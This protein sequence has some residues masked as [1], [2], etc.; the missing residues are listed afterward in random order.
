MK[1]KWLASVMSI[2][3]AVSVLPI[4]GWA[5]ESAA[6]L[7]SV[8]ETPSPVSLSGYLETY[9]VRDFNDP[10]NHK[11]PDFLYSHNRANVLSVNLAMLKASLNTQRLRG[12]LALGSGSYMR[13][14]YAAEPKG[15][16]NIFEANVGVKLSGSHDL[17]LDAGVM[18]SHLGFE[19]AVGTE[20]WTLTRGLMAEN[21]PYF[22]TGAKL[23]YT[24]ADG[25]WMASGLL[26][27][28]WQ[29]IRAPQGN[30][31]PSIG[32]QLTYKP[33]DRVTLNS[34]SFIG[35][36]KSDR[37]RQ[38][39]YFH[40]FYG[41]FKLDE[42]WSLI[43]AFDIGAEQKAP[44]QG[45]GYNVWLAPALLAKYQYS[46]QFSITGRVEYYQDK[47]GVIINTG[48]PHGF[49]TMGYSVNADYKVCPRVTLRAELR[50]LQSRDAIFNESGSRQ[51]DQSLS[52]ATAVAIQ[53]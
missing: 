23:S 39:R 30:T 34:S 45:D 49:K 36:D 52:A 44:G 35:N 21:S 11:R 46:S 38:M 9:Y 28:G 20:N 16:Q 40:D 12:N 51:T 47:Q 25:K 37:D 15:L 13:A 31:T 5:E 2:V 14:N 10:P 3:M 22:E 8:T 1:N 26:L 43:T 18:P 32:H 29:R 19:S 27:N 48:T 17:W 33:N 42:Q 6:P 7:T 24:S 50:Q 53:F 4:A 41:I